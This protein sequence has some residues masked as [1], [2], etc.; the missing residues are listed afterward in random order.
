[1]LELVYEGYCGWESVLKNPRRELLIRDAGS[2]LVKRMVCA[3]GALA[4][5]TPVESTGRSAE[6]TP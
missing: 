1:M 6:R 4:T 2:L 5:W 3:T